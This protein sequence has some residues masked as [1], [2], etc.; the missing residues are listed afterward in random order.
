[1]DKYTIVKT[2]ADEEFQWG[3]ILN[4]STDNVVVEIGG[5]DEFLVYFRNENITYT[6]KIGTGIVE[7]I[8]GKTIDIIKELKQSNIIE[9]KLAE[10]GIA[11]KARLAHIADVGAM[12]EEV[13]QE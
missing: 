12:P 6:F 8:P 11:R 9:L 4:T 5:P 2:I 13:E 3:K 1:M 7:S 10:I